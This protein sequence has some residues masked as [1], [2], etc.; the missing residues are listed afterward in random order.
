MRVVLLMVLGFFIGT[1]LAVADENVRKLMLVTDRAEEACGDFEGGLRRIDVDGFGFLCV[2]N[3][4]FGEGDE[5]LNLGNEYSD[6]YAIILPATD[7]IAEMKMS[8][9]RVIAPKGVAKFSAGNAELKAC[10]PS[11]PVR[12][13][14]T[15]HCD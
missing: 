10:I 1:P 7:M 12:N 9:E 4:A 3:D 5:T 11:A 8:F 15:V 2:G 6:V 14:V 13:E